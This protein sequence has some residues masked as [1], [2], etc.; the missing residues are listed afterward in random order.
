MKPILE[1]R[2]KKDTSK[3]K[4][5]TGGFK[6]IYIENETIDSIEPNF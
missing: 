6:R 4:I 2:K 1:Q 3:E 5:K